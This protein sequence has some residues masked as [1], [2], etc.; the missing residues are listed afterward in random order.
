MKLTQK[1]AEING[2]LIAFVEARV[3]IDNVSFKVK[4]D[5]KQKSFFNYICRNYGFVIGEI[6]V[7]E[8]V[9]EKELVI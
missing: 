7:G 9:E 4:V 6:K 2:K 5:E 1:T 8:K 3:T